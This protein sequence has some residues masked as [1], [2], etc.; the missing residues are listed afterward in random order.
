MNGF[1]FSLA[2]NV[3]LGEESGHYCLYSRIPL[4]ILRLNRTLYTLIEFTQR[5]GSLAEFVKRYPGLNTGNLLGILLSLTSR[6]YLRLDGIPPLESCL[7]VSVI[8]PVKDQFEDA[9]ACL[10]AL[11]ALDYPREKLEI[12]V[13]D[14]HSKTEISRLED[15]FHVRVIRQEI[16]RGPAFSRNL[17]VGSTSGSVLAFLDADCVPGEA[18]LRELLPFFQASSVGA[19]GGYLAGYHQK[20]FLDRYEAVASSLNLGKHLILEGKSKSSF[21]VPTANLLVARE[22]FVKCG[23]FKESM[24]LGEDVDF[25]WRLRNSGYSLLYAPYGTVAHKHRH[26]LDK[27]LQRRAEYG[28]SEAALY[29]RHRDKKKLFDLSVCPALVF[30]ALAVALVM[31]NPYPLCAVPPLF[32]FELWRKSVTLKKH[33]MPLPAGRIACS[34]LRTYLSFF[35]FTSFHLVRYYLVLLLI[36]GFFL[37][38]FWLFV[39]WMLLLASLVDYFTRKPALLYPVFLFFFLLEHLAYQIGVFWGCCR[40]R[41]FGS[42]LVSFRRA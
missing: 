23:G 32:T 1:S 14:D 2:E 13:I 12:V 19:V 17:G 8:I 20:S 31:L 26:R 5:G 40:Q 27:M 4:R 38:P 41:Y 42:Y 34:I 15:S 24:R 37:Y 30:L 16:T 11:G 29:R 28:T 33:R 18:W 3:F 35:Y 39:A 25:C 21:Y 10:E 36:P 6:G 9:V 22:A 7:D